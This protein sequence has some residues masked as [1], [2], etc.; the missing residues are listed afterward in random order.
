MVTLKFLLFFCWRREFWVLIL[1]FNNYY[2]K[3]HLNIIVFFFYYYSLLFCLGLRDSDCVGLSWPVPLS[4]WYKLKSQYLCISHSMEV[5]V[6]VRVCVNNMLGFKLVK[7]NHMCGSMLICR[8]T[9]RLQLPHRPQRRSM[10]RLKIKCTVH[11]T[12]VTTST[13]LIN[14]WDIRGCSPWGS[15]ILIWRLHLVP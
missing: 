6:C 12:N 4:Y 11:F 9:L 8:A 5:C 2:E 15:F 1:L 13:N 3:T 14:L 10:F 7:E